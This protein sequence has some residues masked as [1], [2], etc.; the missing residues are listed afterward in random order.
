M[1]SDV[2]AARVRDLLERIA[3]AADVDVDV[4]ISEDDDG[5]L[6]AEYLGA[7]VAL[8]IGRHGQTIDAIQHLAY[9]IATRGDEPR[10]SVI[11]DADGYRESRA[12]TLRHAADQAVATALRDGREVAL[13]SMTALERK[14]IHEHL[15]DHRDVETFSRGQEPARHLVVAPLLDSDVPLV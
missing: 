6:I 9:R 1:S 13:E 7:D 14:V 3:E 12:Q 10:V 4:D 8:L 2:A 11:V 15:K 5:A